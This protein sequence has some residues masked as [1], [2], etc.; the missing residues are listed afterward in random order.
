VDGLRPA[1]AVGRVPGRDGHRRP[2]GA[3]ESMI[4]LVSTLSRPRVRPGVALGHAG[5]S[6]SPAFNIGARC[7]GYNTK[8]RRYSDVG[9]GTFGFDRYC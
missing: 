7:F 6:R 2:A 1:A 3:A 9:C 8:G 4:E 5:K